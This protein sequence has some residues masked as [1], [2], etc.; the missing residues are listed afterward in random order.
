MRLAH[1][2]DVPQVTLRTGFEVNG[3]EEVLH[4]YL[5]DWP[6]CP[7][8]AVHVLGVV[9]E[10]GL[11]SAVCEEHAPVTEPPRDDAF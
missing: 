9:R 7:N 11:R 10:L 8:V 3:Q 4:E 5:C 2:C 1:S 6:D